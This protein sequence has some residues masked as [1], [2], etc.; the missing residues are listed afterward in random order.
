MK[1]VIF[2]YLVRISIDPKDGGL[3]LHNPENKKSF[4]IN[5]KVEEFLLL[6]NSFKIPK[7]LP[8]GETFN[9]LFKNGFLVE[10]NQKRVQEFK[11]VWEKHNWEDFDYFLKASGDY[12]FVDVDKS[13]GK[14]EEIKVNLFKIYL[15]DSIENNASRSIYEEITKNSDEIFLPNKDL[16]ANK[17]FFPTIFSRRTTRKFNYQK[18]SKEELSWILYK[19]FEEI[20]NRKK[21]VIENLDKSL[22]NLSI[23]HSLWLSAVISVNKVE[24]LENGYY[25][26]N[27]MNH[28]LKLIR[29]D[30]NYEELLK[31]V[32][33]QRFLCGSAFSV[34]ISINFHNIFWR[35]RYSA[36]YKSALLSAVELAQ[37]I[38]TCSVAINLGVF[39]TPAIR[40]ED[41]EKI[42]KSKPL[43]EEFVYY[44]A[45]GK[46]DKEEN[47]SLFAECY[48]ELMG[49]REGDAKKIIDLLNK[50]KKKIK[51]VLD[52]SCGTGSVTNYL[53]KE[54]A[55]EGID[56]SKK[57]IEIAKIKYPHINFYQANMTN[58]NLKTRYD[59]IT[60]NFDSV[61]HLT[62]LDSWVS[63][64]RNAYRHLNKGGVLIFDINTVEK[65]EGLTLLPASVINT[66]NLKVS[67]F[68][69]KVDKNLYNWNLKSEKFEENILESAYSEKLVL[70]ELN[71]LFKKVEVIDYGAKDMRSKN[72]I[73]HFI[74]KK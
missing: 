13:Q 25:Y 40:D 22:S 38:I 9:T 4:F 39:Q 21:S 47:Y 31:I 50:S 74:C 42:L 5:E 30:S 66:Q 11:A 53:S 37:K 1:K 72:K 64:F 60:C 27:Y 41:A 55:I 35:F 3:V 43:I 16:S 63:F 17:S 67:M 51:K 19:S 18:V 70:A 65:L 62:L 48:D 59:A 57:M 45:V 15:N 61:N 14:V 28:S 24:G 58:F 49:D 69:E 29:K 46:Y 2:N 26:Y 20:R 68:V 52:V 56:N 8:K 10:Y 36:A 23:S 12:E 34:F 54:Y 73:L 71:K 7:V 33:G 32:I 6:L 44:L